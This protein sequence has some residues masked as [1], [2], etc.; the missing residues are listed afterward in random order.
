MLLDEVKFPILDLDFL[1]LH[2]LLVDPAENQLISTTGSSS[3][4]HP[5]PVVSPVVAVL[6]LHLLLLH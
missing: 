4:S 1:R 2:R 5:L 3:P 6:Q